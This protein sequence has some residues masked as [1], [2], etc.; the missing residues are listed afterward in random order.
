[1]LRADRK[2]HGGRRRADEENHAIERLEALSIDDAK[3]DRKPAAK[4]KHGG[5]DD[6]YHSVFSAST[7]ERHGKDNDD[8][9]K[10]SA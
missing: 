9:S 1:M 4:R 2:K 7:I 5:G 6:H 8:M 3:D 10:A